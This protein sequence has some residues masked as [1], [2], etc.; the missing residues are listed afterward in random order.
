MKQSL[1]VFI[2]ACVGAMFWFL[3]QSTFHTQGLFFCAV[4]GAWGGIGAFGVLRG[5]VAVAGRGGRSPKVLS[6]V[7]AR[8]FGLF[9]IV[10]LAVFMVIMSSL[11]N[12]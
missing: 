12:K 1:A 6:G 5:E 11:G 2:G 9:I 7:A 4:V 10:A 8:L 3:F